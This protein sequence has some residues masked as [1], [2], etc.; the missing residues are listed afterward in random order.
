MA[1]KGEAKRIYQKEYMRRWSKQRRLDPAYRVRENERA[2]NRVRRNNNGICEACGYDK[3]TDLHHEG[4]E[5][6]ILCP[7]CHALLTRRIKTM[8]DLLGSKLM[9][10]KPPE[11]KQ[12]KL[13]M[14]RTLMANPDA[15]KAE[16]SPLKEESN[17]RLPVYNKRIHKAGDR[18][19][20]DGVEVVV[21]LLDRDGN[22][23][24]EM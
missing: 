19:I 1:L 8:V 10:V 12:E 17:S 3:T 15:L 7:N 18:V 23:I 9:N 21:P 24:P 6:H 13:A 4:K 5:L 11:T 20:K 2:R 22:E 16:S 14:L